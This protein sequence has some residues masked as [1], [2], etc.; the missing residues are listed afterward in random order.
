MALTMN[1]VVSAGMNGGVFISDI[2][3][4]NTD[5]N[6]GNKIFSMDGKVLDSCI[7]DTL[8]LKVHVTAFTGNSNYTPKIK[9]KGTEVT[10]LNEID[11]NGIFTGTINIT[12]TEI[13]ERITALHEDGAKDFV[14]IEY[15]PK[16]EIIEAYFTGGYP[17]GQT[18]LK[19][20]D[21]FDIFIKANTEVVEL[22][23]ADESAFKG[24]VTSGV[25]GSENTVT[26]FIA[27]RGNTAVARYAK[28]RIKDSNGSYSEWF[29]TNSLGTNDGEHTVILNNIRPTLSIGS[30][31]YPV[32][33]EAIKNNESATVNIAANNYSEFLMEPINGELDIID[34]NIYSTTK[35]VKRLSGDY[36]IDTNNFKITL[37]RIQN[38]SSIAKEG[39]VKIVNVPA[40]ITI[41][42]QNENLKSSP[43]GNNNLINLNSNQ[44]L[45]EPP[46]LQ[47]EVGTWVE[48]AFQGGPYDW[49]RNLSIDDSITKGTYN[50]SNLLAKGL[51]GIITS[52][53]TGESEYTL[54]GFKERELSFPPFTRKVDIGTNV[55]DPYSLICTDMSGEEFSYQSSKLNS[56]WGFTIVDS[57]GTPNPNGKY[58]YITDDNWVYKNS[59]GL[60]YVTIKEI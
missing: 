9:V 54:A 13:D 32:D 20:N 34:P 48:L 29:F 57:D 24:L 47:A 7:T 50:W 39:L 6:I 58:I 40:E 19:E 43:T 52:T 60:A 10:S 53:I 8:N 42:E 15:V 44:E 46:T 28:V 51:S 38:D 12:I 55:V 17:G 41:S 49:T 4:L 1:D 30:I 26:N 5:D 25:S 37:N 2:T 23:I 18:E 27:D 31:T 22:E 11:N 45:I 33:Q 3:P 56:S 35:E 36:N 14:E 21:T 59:E 16:P